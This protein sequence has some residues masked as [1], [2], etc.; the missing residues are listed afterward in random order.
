MIRRI[1][2]EDAEGKETGC[3]GGNKNHQNC[4][5]GITGRST[6]ADLKAITIPASQSE[7]RQMLL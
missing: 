7:V 3:S 5:D 1:R 6:K 2:R 4:C